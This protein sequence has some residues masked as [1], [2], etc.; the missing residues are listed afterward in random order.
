LPDG[1]EAEQALVFT[2]VPRYYETTWFRL[3]CVSAFAWIV[4]VGYRFRVRQVHARFQTV[5]DERARL[6]REVHDTLAQ[7]FVGISSQLAVVESYLPPEDSPGRQSLDIAR[8]MAQYSLGEARRSVMDLRATALDDTDLS[9]ALRL[10]VHQ[11]TAG[12]GLEIETEVV[13]D[14]SGLPE[15]VAH[16]ILRMA[17]EGVNN[18]VKHAR[19]STVQLRLTV[20]HKRLTLLIQ[21]DGCGFDPEGMLASS[22][23]N[24]GLMGMRERAERL[25]GEFVLHSQPGQGTELMCA[26]PLQP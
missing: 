12:S 5:L 1:A 11:W 24:F 23:A 15:D 3:L 10:G 2:V 13:G 25:G 18:V 22:Q 26:V 9:G 20:D 7:G 6:A 16:H 8:R 17:Q 14:A 21:D 19:A 4:W